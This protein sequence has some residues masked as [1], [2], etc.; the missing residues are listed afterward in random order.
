[1]YKL[2]KL[3]SEYYLVSDIEPKD[4]NPCMTFHKE[5]KLPMI[6]DYYQ[7]DA[8]SYVHKPMSIVASTKRI[9]RMKELL[10]MDKKQIE[11]SLCKIDVEA[12][13]EE[14]SEGRYPVLTHSAPELS[15][16]KG[17][18]I[19]FK[20]GVWFG[21]AQALKDNSDKKFTLQDIK[22]AYIQGGFDSNSMA[23]RLHKD[24]KSYLSAE[25]YLESLNKEQTEWDVEVEMEKD[26]Y[27]VSGGLIPDGEIGGKGLETHWSYKPKVNQEGYINILNIK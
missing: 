9:V 25:E 7:G 17:S 15:P 23:K 22:K 5:T 24:I 18:K 13:A 2:I 27:V 20:H 8:N 3:N 11:E 6:D 19:T 12:L 1:M 14:E 21:Y 16:Y 4:R 26:N 10:L